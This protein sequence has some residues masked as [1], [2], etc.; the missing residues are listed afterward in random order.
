METVNAEAE[1]DRQIDVLRSIQ[2]LSPAPEAERRRGLTGL[3]GFITSDTQTKA[4][5]FSETP[6]LGLSELQTSAGFDL[7]I[8]E[9][10][11]MKRAL[12]R[13]DS[14]ATPSSTDTRNGT[15]LAP[16]AKIEIPQTARSSQLNTPEFIPH[17]LPTP[18]SFGAFMYRQG[19]PMAPKL[20]IKQVRKRL[21][22]YISHQLMQIFA[23]MIRLFCKA[24]MNF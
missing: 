1:A 7:S 3:E 6:L 18:K 12:S 15:E 17:G 2:E 10:L 23:R 9:K 8:V 21:K 20:H 24:R 22:I 4:E 16:E 11:P 13:L 19:W 14:L 5:V